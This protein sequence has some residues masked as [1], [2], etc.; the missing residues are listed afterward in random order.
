ML[1]LPATRWHMGFHFFFLFLNWAIL[2]SCIFGNS[3]LNLLKSPFITSHPSV[4]CVELN[5]FLSIGLHIHIHSLCGSHKFLAIYWVFCGEYQFLTLD[6]S[7]LIHLSTICILCSCILLTSIFAGKHS[8]SETPPGLFTH[9]HDYDT[10]L[11]III[12]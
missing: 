9:N 6:N 4:I 10:K 1:N 8:L 5:W 2:H 3:W 12:H 7:T 11:H